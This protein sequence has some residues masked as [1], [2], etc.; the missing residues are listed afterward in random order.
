MTPRAEVVPLSREEFRTWLV[1]LL[2]RD[3]EP[4]DRRIITKIL[5][6]RPYVYGRTSVKVVRQLLRQ[7]KRSLNGIVRGSDDGWQS[8]VC[9]LRREVVTPFH[10]DAARVLARKLDAAHAFADEDRGFGDQVF[11]TLGVK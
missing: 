9:L 6:L 10:E 2:V 11:R 7:E 1:L 8:D 5:R 4:C 3:G